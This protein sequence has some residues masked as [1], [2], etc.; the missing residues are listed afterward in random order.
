VRT[1]VIKE[2]EVEG[3]VAPRQI[4]TFRGLSSAE[5]IS[6]NGGTVATHHNSAVGLSSLKLQLQLQ[7]VLPPLTL[8]LLSP[9]TDSA[10]QSLLLLVFPPLTMKLPLLELEHH[11]VIFPITTNLH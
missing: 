1:E 2:F 8:T 4:M 5:S 10:R 7:L 6:A 3:D 11:H 9:I